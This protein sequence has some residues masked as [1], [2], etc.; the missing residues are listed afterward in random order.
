MKKL[1]AAYL[2]LIT[3]SVYAY[4]HTG[5]LANN[6][7]WVAIATIFIYQIVKHDSKRTIY[8]ITWASLIVV[9]GIFSTGI[10]VLLFI[11]SLLGSLLYGLYFDDDNGLTR[12]NKTPG[13]PDLTVSTNQSTAKEVDSNP[14]K[15]NIPYMS[16]R[17]V[18]R[19]IK[20]NIKKEGRIKK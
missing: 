11:F 19:M 8:F 14:Q 20:K 16:D 15:Y 12:Q 3:N 17:A 6:L 5:G 1:L 9:V 10:M 4:S 2:I 18:E 7:A 13:M